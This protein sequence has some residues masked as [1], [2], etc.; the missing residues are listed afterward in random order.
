MINKGKNFF[1]TPVDEKSCKFCC[2][3]SINNT[4]Q[5]YNSFAKWVGKNETLTSCDGKNSYLV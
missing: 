3:W 1:L 5:E 2:F 4:S